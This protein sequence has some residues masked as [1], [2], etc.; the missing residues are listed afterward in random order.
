MT[1]YEAERA[2]LMS[3]TATALEDAA[4]QFCEEI[5]D[6]DDLNC[7]LG[8]AEIQRGKIA[9]FNENPQLCKWRYLDEENNIVELED[10]EAA[11]N[12]MKENDDCPYESFKDYLKACMEYNGGTLTSIL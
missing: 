11:Y 9:K 1:F 3:A 7:L 8:L 4:Y 12:D 6:F 5:D 10:L 2:I